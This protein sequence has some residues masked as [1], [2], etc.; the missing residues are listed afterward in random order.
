MSEQNRLTAQDREDLRPNVV[1]RDTDGFN[2]IA[3]RQETE[4]WAAAERILA[5]HLSDLEARIADLEE[6]SCVVGRKHLDEVAA[7]KAR[8]ESAEARVADAAELGALEA[9][10]RAAA[11][12]GMPLLDILQEE[13]HI[14]E[15]DAVISGNLTLCDCWWQ[16]VK[17]AAAAMSEIATAAEDSLAALRE[18]SVPG[19]GRGEDE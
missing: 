18:R 6:K 14:D 5:R 4:I 16:R 3:M 8:A 17:A 19:V 11:S 13:G 2:S 7:W 15:C 12:W 1:F 9:T 10:R